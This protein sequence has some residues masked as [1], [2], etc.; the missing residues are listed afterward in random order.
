MNVLVIDNYDSFVYN[1][2]HSLE[3]LGARCTVV[4]NDAVTVDEVRTFNPD[5]I[6][7]SPGPGVPGD[8]RDF[9][10]CGDVLT[11][12]SH[13]V[14]T[15]GVCLGHQGIAHHYG[16]H[17][18]R[19]PAVHGKTSL[20]EHDGTGIYEGLPAPFTAGR[21]HS[22]VVADDLPPELEVVSRT[23]DG[24]IMGIRHRCYPIEGVQFHPESVLTP[25]GQM[26][27]ANFLR[28]ARA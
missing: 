11:S 15:L 23:A 24:T 5:A 17:V 18:V 7:I 2:S 12:I 1:L 27:L 28:G 6:V 10:V 9:G 14:P 26:V 3:D 22:Y 13:E 16:G 8:R 25:D 21:Y 20:V 4:R 19:A